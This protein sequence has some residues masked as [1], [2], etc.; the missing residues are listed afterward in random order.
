MTDTPQVR[1]TVAWKTWMAVR[2]IIF[3]IGG[4]IALWIS[5][6]SLIIFAVDPPG[7]RWLSPFLTVPL[8]FV[9]ALMMLYGGGQGGRWAYLF[10]VW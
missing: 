9:G 3:G 7:E 2:F 6:L 1:A 5:W 10:V 8:S 4:F